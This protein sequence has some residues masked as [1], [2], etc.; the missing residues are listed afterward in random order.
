MQPV[1][2]H[3]GWVFETHIQHRVLHPE[4]EY[5]SWPRGQSLQFV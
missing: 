4:H 1:V 2:K 5:A 3:W